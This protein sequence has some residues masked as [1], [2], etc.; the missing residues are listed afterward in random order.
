MAEDELPGLDLNQYLSEL[1][2]MGLFIHDVENKKAYPNNLWDSLGYTSGEMAEMGFLDFVHPDDKNEVINAYGKTS[3]SIPGSQRIKFRIKNRVGEWRWVLSSTIG[4][5]KNK[6]GETLRFIGFDHDITSEVEMR[7]KAEAALKEA[8]SMIK[9]AEIISSNLNLENTVAAVLEQAETVFSF[10]SASVQLSEGGR[11][12]IVGDIGLKRECS[13]E[14]IAFSIG[15]GT[16]N[17]HVIKSRKPYIVNRELRKTYPDFIDNSVA[18]INSWMGIPLLYKDQLI[19]MIAFDHAEE[20]HFN[21]SDIRFAQAFANQVAIALGNA[22][23]YEE[24]KNLAVRD[25]LTGCFSR[26]HFFESLDSESKQAVRYG[27]P[28]SVMMFDADDFKLVND[29]WGHVTGDWVLKELAGAASRCLRNT[30]ILCRYGGEEFIVLM[31]STGLDETC[32]VAER[33]RQS[34]EELTFDGNGITATVSIGCTVFC[35]A[36]YENPDNMIMRVDKAMY[37][38]KESGKNRITRILPPE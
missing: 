6:K 19:G 11:L 37:E 29:Q 25:Q 1:R 9:A 23:L 10:T 4:L 31:P 14:E 20:G 27:T 32:I 12:K 5:E 21:Y 24:V 22:R 16:P 3:A 26:R 8:E 34:I 13:G 17:H 15:P 36:D 18:G 2:G 30:D 35:E 28:L 33:V 7:M 38:S